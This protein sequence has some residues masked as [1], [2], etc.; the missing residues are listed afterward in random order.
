MALS[1]P[2]ETSGKYSKHRIMKMATTISE[3]RSFSA[4]EP[5]FILLLLLLC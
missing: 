1:K 5:V 2:D 4:A 3:R